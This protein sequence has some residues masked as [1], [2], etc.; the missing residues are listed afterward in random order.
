LGAF[1]LSLFGNIRAY[2]QES[3]R[4]KHVALW[5]TLLLERHTF[6]CV[7]Y[8]IPFTFCWG[9]L[10]PVCKTLKNTLL[11]ELGDW[12]AGVALLF[13]LLSNT[14]DVYRWIGRQLRHV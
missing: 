12:R 11:F 5:E 14:E 1:F 6:V 8:R 2:H 10:L 13:S 3:E 9:V 4:D 7:G